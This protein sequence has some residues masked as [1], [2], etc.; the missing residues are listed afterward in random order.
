LRDSRYRRVLWAV[1]VINTAMFLVEIIAGLAARSASLQADALD[2]FADAANY[3][4]S[5]FVLGMTLRYRASAALA[6]G[7][8]MGLSACGCCHVCLPCGLWNGAGSR[9]N[10]RGR[11]FGALGQCCVFRSVLGL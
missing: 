3:A 1:L 2:F 6:K 10:G 5:L 9:D 8:T 4:I 7:V 11:R